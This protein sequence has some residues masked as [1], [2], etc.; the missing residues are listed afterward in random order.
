MTM[1]TR[2]DLILVR[3]L[4]ITGRN[5]DYGDRVGMSGMTRDVRDEDGY[6]EMQGLTGITRDD[7]G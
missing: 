1:R 7:Q 6:E 5:K 4:D 3:R 2:G